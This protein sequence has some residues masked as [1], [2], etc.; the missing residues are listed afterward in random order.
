MKATVDQSMC[1]GCGLCPSI[2]SEVFAMNEEG[3]S[4]A[5]VEEVPVSSEDEA[6]EAEV[7]CPVEPIT[8]Q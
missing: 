3:K 7:S 8:V 4:H 1:I 6:K 2:C 5:I